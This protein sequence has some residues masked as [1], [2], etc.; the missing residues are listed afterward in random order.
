MECAQP[1]VSLLLNRLE[2]SGREET[3]R[4]GTVHRDHPNAQDSACPAACGHA[5]T[6]PSPS[7]AHSCLQGSR[8]EWAGDAGPRATHANF[9]SFSQ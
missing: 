7:L 4:R 1:S 3:W 8:P 6:P 5:S 2:R 9:C